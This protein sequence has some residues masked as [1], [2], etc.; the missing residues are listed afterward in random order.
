MSGPQRVSDPDLPAP[1]QALFDPAS[2]LKC[3]KGRAQPSWGHGSAQNVTSVH[4]KGNWLQAGAASLCC[5]A[6]EHRLLP[7]PSRYYWN[8][9]TNVTTYQRPGPAAAP[10]AAA[11]SSYDNYRVGAV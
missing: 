7:V 1:W 11:P 3:V 10:P 6:P 9:S 2:N 4:T 5:L 8:P